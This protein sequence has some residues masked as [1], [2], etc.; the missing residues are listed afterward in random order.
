MKRTL[1]NIADRMQAP[2][3][4]I[5]MISSFSISGNYRMLQQ[6]RVVVKRVWRKWL[7][8]RRAGPCSWDSLGY[9]WQRYPLP[10][11]RVV[12]SIYRVAANP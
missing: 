9:I 7:A 11:A 5:S 4:T 10:E 8:R 3:E 6:V 2:Q 1:F 12:Q